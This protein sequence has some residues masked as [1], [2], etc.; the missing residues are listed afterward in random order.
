MQYVGK[1][2]VENIGEALAGA[3]DIIAEAIAEHAFARGKIRDLAFHRATIVCEEKKKGEA[4]ADRHKYASYAGSKME[5][6]KAPAFAIHA[7]FRGEREGFLKLSIAPPESAAL[8]LLRQIFVKGDGVESSQVDLALR[9]AYKR[10][11][12]PSMENELRAAMRERAD[13]A[14]I[15]VFSQNLRTLLMAPPLGEKR[16]LAVDP[17]FRTGCKI[18]V[19]DAQG[20]LLAYDTIH[21]FGSA[22]KEGEA[23]ALVASW[24]DRYAVEFVAVGNGTGGRETEAWLKKIGVTVPV[25]SVSESG[26][27]VYSASEVA[28]REFPDLALYLADCSSF[29]F[30]WW[31]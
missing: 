4:D 30:I 10:L 2:G 21:P 29:S 11:L 3:R 8:T 6:S 15:R 25:I 24:L 18:A 31:P 27:S 23:G 19:L 14:A 13:E 1:Q 26:A 17:G 7:M 20:L 9:D 22:A 16:I 12:T 28:R 5:A